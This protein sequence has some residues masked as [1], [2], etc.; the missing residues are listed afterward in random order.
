V[1][2]AAP[3]RDAARVRLRQVPWRTVRRV[4]IPFHHA[5]LPWA[6]VA[7]ETALDSGADEV[8]ALAADEDAV[9]VGAFASG[10]RV[11]TAA[12]VGISEERVAITAA[13]HGTPLTPRVIVAEAIDALGGDAATLVLAPTV[14]VVAPLESLWAALETHPVVLV[15]NILDPSHDIVPQRRMGLEKR[16][17]SAPTDALASPMIGLVNASVIGVRPSL[18]RGVLDR[19]PG[20]MGAASHYDAI[21]P[22]R[23]EGWLAGLAVTPGVHVLRDPGVG[24]AW[25][26]LHERAVLAG[27]DGLTANGVPLT[28]MDLRGHDPR[29]PNVLC[30]G[31][32]IGFL[33]ETPALI[34]EVHAHSRALNAAGAALDHGEGAL[35]DHLHHQGR[36]ATLPNGDQLV[37]PMRNLYRTMV[38]EGELTRSPF[39]PDGQAEMIAAFRRPGPRGKPA[40]VNQF[41][42]SLWVDREELR[43]AYPKL[44]GG[45][46][47]G[48]IGWVWEYGRSRELIPESVMPDLAERFAAGD[49]I[50]GDPS[51]AP[52]ESRM[53]AHRGGQIDGVN[54]A[55]FFSAQLGLGE[56]VRQLVHAI[57]VRDIDVVPV[58]GRVIPS[59]RGESD[60]G[61]VTPDHAEHPVTILMLNGDSIPL[62]AEDVGEDFF[63]D[64]YTIG[65]YWWEVDP[66]PAD[67]W[68]PA[69][70]YVDELW[71]G[72][73]FVGDIL[74]R[75]HGVNVPVTVVRV[76]VAD[77][78]AVTCDRAHFGLPEDATLFGFVYDY[79][80]SGQR[81]NP[82]GLV[83]AYTQAFAPGD[84]AHLVLKCLGSVHRS[85]DHEEVLV[86]AS[87]RD[88]ITIIDRYL[89]TAEKDSLVGIC[90]CYVSPHRSEGFGYTL[91]EAMAYGKPVICTDYAGVQD[92]ATEETALLVKATPSVTG[93]FAIPYPPDSKWADPDV[94]DLAAKMRWVHEH[95]D[96][97]KALGRRASEVIRETHSYQAAGASMEARLKEIYEDIDQRKGSSPVPAA[98]GLT[99]RRRA[100]DTAMRVP[101]VGRGLR[102]ARASWWSLMDRA[103]ASRTRPVL[104]G[105][106]DAHHG[107]LSADREIAKLREELQGGVHVAADQAVRVRALERALGR[108]T[109]VFDDMRGTLD[110]TRASL[111]DTRADLARHEERH[112]P[113]PYGVVESGMEIVDTP[114][115][116]RALHQAFNGNADQ[117]YAAF[118]D[119]FR[120]DWDRVREMAELYG[121][122]LVGHGPVLDL[123][124]GRGELLDVLREHGI[125]ARGVDLTPELVEQARSRGLDAELG[126]AIEVVRALEPGS[127]GAI[128]A[129]HVIEHL[130][131]SVLEELLRKSHAALRPDGLIV[132]ETVNVHDMLGAA[133][134]WLD[135][136]HKRPI[137]AEA[138]LAATGAAGFAEGW[139]FAPGGTGDWEVDRSS[140]SRYTVVARR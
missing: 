10:I 99:T 132:L 135:L 77:P 139:I 126:D 134:F 23:F 66:Y 42:W 7:A 112:S 89:T 33:S 102:R 20:R 3:D 108:V 56:S 125:E 32:S 96:E 101:L 90:D 22:V 103:V 53:S 34:G 67:A 31:T 72:T 57:R 85:D 120:G 8:V 55:G 95:P 107:L 25:F 50:L 106:R 137:L 114:G 116:G 78:P 82:L 123:G 48:L 47:P 105:L 74:R 111:H 128:T 2:P 15:S 83:Q 113:V 76:P 124:C 98:A 62:F 94:D 49:V 45:D 140:V 39:T 86:A 54:V 69:L 29:R 81:K 136:T 65:F 41:V 46:G 16:A 51:L 129:L 71:A 121:E 115:Y 130:E 28:L 70:E 38:A 9:P 110:Q 84:G 58:Q 93:P 104:T 1:Q 43:T 36:W 35:A 122:L 75:G 131:P 118:L 37:T 40:G 14:R 138:L 4:L 88:D 133:A 100:F 13:A 18:G 92:F 17:P 30:P 5:D 79:E 63:R 24:L 64:R 19:W 6:R 91:A 26:N 61:Y 68:N 12:D 27:E 97:A 11:L 21:D 44:E 117:S 80:S 119:C 52:P 73:E 59:G 109:G 60:F 127:L 87:G